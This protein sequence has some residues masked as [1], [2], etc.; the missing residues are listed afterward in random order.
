MNIRKEP[1]LELIG[2]SI[3]LSGTLPLDVS[4]IETENLS[5]SVPLISPHV[6]RL[7]RLRTRVV[8]IHATRD[9]SLVTFL[10]QPMS[11]L[12][13]LEV[14]FIPKIE[15]MPYLALD[16][17]RPPEDLDPFLWNSEINHC[18]DLRHLCLGRGVEL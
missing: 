4:F 5:A 17:G 12:K 3:Q 1:N 14:R 2:L 13:N 18:P 6:L 16:D 8:G 9:E 11:N 15:P 7:L 10:R